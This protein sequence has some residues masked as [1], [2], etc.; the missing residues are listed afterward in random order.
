MIH[1]VLLLYFLSLRKVIFLCKTRLY[2]YIILYSPYYYIDFNESN[3]IKTILIILNFH[4]I[5]VIISITIL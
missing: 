4:I 5:Y 2:Y 1:F 3:I